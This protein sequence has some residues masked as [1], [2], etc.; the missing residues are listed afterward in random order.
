MSARKKTETEQENPEW[1]ANDFARA[2]PAHE[3]LPPEALSVFK[4]TRGPQ[5]A[6]RKVPVSIRLSADVVEHFKASG[7]GWQGRIDETLKKA[8]GRVR[9]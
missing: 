1:T 4:R 7:P 6:A 5:R 2:R 9:G 8:I 3:V